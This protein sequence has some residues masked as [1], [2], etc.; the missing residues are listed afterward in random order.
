VPT[1]GGGPDLTSSANPRV[2]SLLTLR[3]P[4]TRAELGRTLVEGYD[5]V[6]L[7]V[8]V[9]VEVFEL[10]VCPDLAEPG[11]VAEV[12]AVAPVRPV[13][14]SRAVFEKVSYRDS[15][16]GFLAVCRPPGVALD[17]VRLPE[18]PMVVVC[19]GI[20]KPGNLG[21]ILRTADAAGVD[22]VISADPRTDLANPNVI[23]ASRGAAYAVPVATA[24]LGTAYAWLA[25][26]DIAVGAASPDATTPHTEAD[27][28]GA[29]AIVVGTEHEG[30]TEAA[31]R[32]AD[33]LVRIPMSGR[34]NSL[35]VSVSLA[36]L[37]YEAVRQRG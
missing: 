10:Y 21:A 34:L 14:V 1:S 18:R 8:T 12:V 24:D 15:P 26:R 37:V 25:E 30:L 31:G 35:N 20:E 2:K 28:R 16:D 7:V 33:T 22:L 4:R 19:E 23:R 11:R 29:V 9:G 32:R 36:V 17:E 3:R 6:L 13:T 5:E 27:L